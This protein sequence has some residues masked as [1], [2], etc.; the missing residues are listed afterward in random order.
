MDQPATQA[1]VII[2]DKNYFGT[3]FENTLTA[4]GIEL[5]R[6]ARK[7][8]APRPGRQFLRPFRQIIESVNQTFKGQ[9]NLE[10]HA[11]RTIAG[12]CSRITQRVLALTAAIW[13]NDLTGAPHTTNPDPLRPL[14]T[15]WNQ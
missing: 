11:G 5:I 9:L 10:R 3:G 8:E 6:P 1:Q 4:A 7:G 15:P 14:T 13:H 2:A 12:V